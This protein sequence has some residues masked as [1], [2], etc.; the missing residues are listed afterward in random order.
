MGKAVVKQSL[1]LH[2]GGMQYGRKC[3]RIDPSTPLGIKMTWY[4]TYQRQYSDRDDRQYC[5]FRCLA[6]Y[7]PP[8]ELQIEVRHGNNEFLA[9]LFDLVVDRQ[10]E[11]SFVGAT[12][13]NMDEKRAAQTR[14]SPQSS[15][16]E[17]SFDTAVSEFLDERYTLGV[18]AISESLDFAQMSSAYF[19]DDENCSFEE[20]EYSQ[21]AYIR[22][23][24]SSPQ[25]PP[26]GQSQQTSDVE[27]SPAQ[28]TVASPMNILKMIDAQ[29]TVSRQPPVRDGSISPKSLMNERQEKEATCTVTDCAS[30]G[31]QETN[32]AIQ[33]ETDETQLPEPMEA[34]TDANI[35]VNNNIMIKKEVMTPSPSGSDPS[36]SEREEATVSKPGEVKINKFTD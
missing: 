17:T 36:E 33:V 4:G 9:H 30:N 19:F 2:Q 34:E 35:T 24:N 23:I 8:S 28:Q 13:T 25:N 15:T 3:E 11:A 22:Q 7:Q 6:N 18:F 27:M 31:A 20:V 10:N 26:I 21:P 29:T 14:T 32:A 16:G 12:A 5:Y 1:T